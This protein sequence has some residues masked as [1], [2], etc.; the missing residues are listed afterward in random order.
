MA[1]LWAT[2]TLPSEE[3]DADR[4]GSL[5]R[6]LLMGTVPCLPELRRIVKY[7]CVCL[8]GNHGLIKEA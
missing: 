4:L 7:A 1:F 2:L 5:P 8:L 3:G 6:G